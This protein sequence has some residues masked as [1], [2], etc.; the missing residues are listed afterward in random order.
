MFR[1]WLAKTV[2]LLRTV[3]VTLVPQQSSM[4]V[5][6]SKVHPEPHSTV[7]GPAQMT[8]GGLVSMM[9]TVSV[10]SAAL[11]QQSVACHVRVM[12]WLQGMD[13]LVTALTSETITALQHASNAAGGTGVQPTPLGPTLP[14]EYV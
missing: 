9:L 1:R 8:T 14:Q 4:A 13:P 5:G 11:L 7:L 6:V 2:T 10:Q 3:I 12:I